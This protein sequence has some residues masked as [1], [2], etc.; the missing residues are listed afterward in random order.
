MTLNL[1][2]QQFL[3]LA[4]L[5]RSARPAMSRS[6]EGELSLENSE[7]KLKIKWTPDQIDITVN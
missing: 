3:D 4:S 2:K 6:D 5:I 1:S 7:K